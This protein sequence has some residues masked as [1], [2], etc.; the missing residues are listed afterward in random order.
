MSEAGVLTIFTADREIS[1]RSGQ[2]LLALVD[3]KREIRAQSEHS[4]L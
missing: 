4:N 2:T 1:P 3:P